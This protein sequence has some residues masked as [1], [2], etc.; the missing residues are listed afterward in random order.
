MS[1]SKEDNHGARTLPSEESLKLEIVAASSNVRRIEPALELIDKSLSKDGKAEET[2]K[3]L[4]RI[5]EFSSAVA[6]SSHSDAAIP[7]TDPAAIDLDI[8]E[9]VVITDESYKI[10]LLTNSARELFKLRR[11]SDLSK[12]FEGY[13]E[14]RF[15]DH[16]DA[17]KKTWSLQFDGGNRYSAD[18]YQVWSESKKRHLYLFVFQCLALSAEEKKRITNAFSLTS[19]EIGIIELI[20]LRLSVPEIAKIKRI[21]VATARK[22]IANILEKTKT[23]S[24]L[25]ATLRLLE[26]K[27]P[28]QAPTTGYRTADESPGATRTAFFR[29]PFPAQIDYEG[30]TSF[31][32]PTLFY[33]HSLENRF[34]PPSAFIDQI[35]ASG[36]A[37]CC[38][39][40]PGFGSSSQ[41]SSLSDDA[42][43]YANLI[44]R[45]GIKECIIVAQNTAVPGGL[46]LLESA[47]QA[48]GL[49]M[50]NFVPG[51]FDKLSK[52]NPRWL[53][54]F[55]EIAAKHDSHQMFGIRL[56]QNL[57][58]VVGPYNFYSKLFL[59]CDV[60]REFCSRHKESVLTA[61][62]HLVDVS[63][64]VLA[65]NIRKSIQPLQNP[66]L[67]SIKKPLLAVRGR[68]SMPAF[69]QELETV[70][71]AAGIPFKLIPD[72]GRFCFFQQ[73]E[74]V[75]DFISAEMR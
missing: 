52:F 39:V 74:M 11:N 59:D 48:K 18:L 26:Y 51:E 49:A 43:L 12:Y 67:R 72:A 33:L 38:P 7:A 69:N 44:K 32:A 14:T 10:L 55:L 25:N 73:T 19:A 66:K 21:S 54:S 29:K 61:V 22:H 63:P 70:C 75:L 42:T 8:P 47:R 4:S 2:K 9:Y 71:K 57:V 53:R 28:T 36:Y 56:I 45:L 24:V 13:S 41:T 3:L 58:K 6:S 34:P 15:H 16:N 40:R 35:E 60:D 27:I 37:I 30:S 50:V 68:D 64:A 5:L 1:K 17:L 20:L 23:N 31:D 65:V 62:K 46:H